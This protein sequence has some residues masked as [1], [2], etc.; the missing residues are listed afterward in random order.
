[1][2]NGHILIFEFR[3]Q[4]KYQFLTTVSIRIFFFISF[5]SSNVYVY[6]GLQFGEVKHKIII[7]HFFQIAIFAFFFNATSKIKCCRHL[8]AVFVEA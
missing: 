6:Q 7:E 2:T 3:I 8:N 5:F 4:R 1:M